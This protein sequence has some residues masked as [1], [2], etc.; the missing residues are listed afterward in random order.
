MAED[1][2]EFINQHIVMGRHLNAYKHLFGGAMLS[3]LDEAGAMFVVEKIQYEN[4]VT[5]A[6]NNVVFQNPAK[7]GSR[8]KF[9]GK[10]NK[11]GSS[12]VTVLL[13]AIR[14]D[15]DKAKILPIIECEI[16]YVCIDEEGKPYKLFVS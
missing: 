10:V 1:G 13:K 12:S 2:Y 3:W 5:V 15:I 8:I 14:K 9:Y 6:M 11:T 16:T 7:L 4:I